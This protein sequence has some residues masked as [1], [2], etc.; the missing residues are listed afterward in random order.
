[1]DKRK[2]L[3]YDL[4]KQFSSKLTRI[5]L[6]QLLWAGHYV[7]SEGNGLTF[8]QVFEIVDEAMNYVSS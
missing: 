6:L 5:E 8:G 2:A 7:Y 3:V 1:M 4:I